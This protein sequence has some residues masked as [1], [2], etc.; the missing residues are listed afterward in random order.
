M[1]KKILIDQPGYLGDIIF[2]MAIAQKYVKDGH[3]VDFPMFDEYFDASLQKYFPTINIFPLSQLPTYNK[4]HSVDMVEDETYHCLPL[5]ASATRSAYPHMDNKYGFLGLPFTM[6]RDI[7]ITRDYNAENKLFNELGLKEGD[8]YNLINEYHQKAFVK[9]PISVDNGNKNIYMSKID[10]Y[11]IFDWIKV[12][13]NAQS[14]HTVATSIIFILDVIEIISNDVH[15]YK[16]HNLNTHRDYDYLL[17]K[18]YIYH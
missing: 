15:I 2:V 9:M 18:K 16:R 13:E 6:W 11:S 3:I 5:R 7:E 14:I 17:K 8:K 12:M 1:S 10:G 4:Y